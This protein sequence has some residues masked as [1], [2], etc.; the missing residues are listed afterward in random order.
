MVNEIYDELVDAKK[1]KSES[2]VQKIGHLDTAVY[3]NEYDLPS[4]FEKML[5]LSILYTAPSADARAASTAYVKGDRRTYGGKNYIA[6][7]DHTSTASFPYTK[8]YTTTAIMT[9]ADT[10]TINWVVF[11]A[12][13]IWVCVNPGDFYIG[14]DET[15]GNVN[16][17]ACI[18]S[19]TWWSA[20]TFIALDEY[21]KKLLSDI[22]LVATNATIH[23]IELTYNK[24]ITTSETSGTGS[25]G[26]ETGGWWIQVYEWYVNVTPW[27]INYDNME[28]YNMQTTNSPIYFY[29]E[30]KLRI[31]PYPTEV[32]YDGIKLNY[33]QSNTELTTT[34]N[35]LLLKIESKF[36][37]AREYGVAYKMCD[38]T[39][40]DSSKNQMEYEKAKLEAMTRWSN[41]HFSKV[42]EFLPPLVNYRR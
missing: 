25:R 31:Y 2:F 11:T 42:H 36:H 12:K 7:A 16:L 39:Q 29:L 18:R 32:V 26:T 23:T 21:N 4:D 22:N 9:A 34:T 28:S 6:T 30:W 15:A 40:T 5:Q 3:Q 10:I 17:L 8:T 13:A 24:S 33:I 38:F 20:T 1:A 41:R 37:K 35:D 27:K 14:L 19:L